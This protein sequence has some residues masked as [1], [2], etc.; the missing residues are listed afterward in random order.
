MSTY[1]RLAVALTAVGIVTAGLS[2]NALG[3][4]A[5]AADDSFGR[6]VSMY[7]QMSFGQGH[8]AHEVICTHDGMTMTFASFGAMLRHMHMHAHC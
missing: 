8:D 3:A 5:R 1:H 6:Q 7:A 2:A 4:N